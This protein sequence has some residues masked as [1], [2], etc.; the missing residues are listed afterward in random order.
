MM[1][2]MLVLD[3]DWLWDEVASMTTLLLLL[4]PLHVK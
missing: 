1:V 3:S 4:D 2:R